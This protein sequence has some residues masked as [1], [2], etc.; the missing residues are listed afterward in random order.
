MQKDFVNGALGTKEAQA[1]VPN[2]V[3][4]I[5][6]Y[7]PNEIVFTKDTHTESYPN[8]LEGQKLPVPHC[9][10][11][12]EG[13]KI[14]PELSVYIK[15]NVPV[16]E[17][18]VVKEKSTFGSIDLY[19]LCSER[20]W[21]DPDIIYQC[22]EIELCGVCTDICVIS[23]ALLLRAHYPDTKIIVHANCCAGV[24]PELHE[25][26][27]KVMESCQIDVIR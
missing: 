19:K 7:K 9:I 11:D 16:I 12:T 17:N 22:D 20:D 14:I 5:K 6:E 26:A 27:L 3:K 15:D 23:N 24:T 13:W 4:R 1:I 18:P 10:R 25:A 8:T 2:I 21:N